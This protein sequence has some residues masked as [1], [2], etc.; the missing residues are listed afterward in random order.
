M[1]NS[2]LSYFGYNNN[3]KR[4]KPENLELMFGILGLD[5][6]EQIL[7][8]ATAG[9]A[10]PV[11]VLHRELRKRM[12]ISRT[13]LICALERLERRD[14]VTKSFNRDYLWRSNLPKICR[15]LKNLATAH[16][17]TIPS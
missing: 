14:L 13:T 17:I 8:L 15:K 4:L 12:R 9:M 10:K 3:L 11:R 5:E 6:N 1:E 7:I 2:F 16:I